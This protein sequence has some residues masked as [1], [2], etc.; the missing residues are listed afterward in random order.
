[1]VVHDLL[2]NDEFMRWAL[3]GSVYFLFCAMCWRS[4]KPGQPRRHRRH[5]P[6]NIFT[7]ALLPVLALAVAPS[8][9]T[10]ALIRALKGDFRRNRLR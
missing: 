5:A 10:V 2:S 9:L 4:W 8:F 6:W 1:M 7:L 3:I